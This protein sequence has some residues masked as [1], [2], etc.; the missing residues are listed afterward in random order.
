METMIEIGL[1]EVMSIV[2]VSLSGEAPK[3][4]FRHMCLIFV[5]LVRN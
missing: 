1:C 4:K 3:Q 2:A 5:A